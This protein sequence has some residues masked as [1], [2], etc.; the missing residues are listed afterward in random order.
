[1]SL[2]IG[3]Y[4][5]FYV[6]EPFN[7]SRLGANATRDFLYYNLIKAWSASDAS[8]NFRDSHALTYNVRDGSDWETT[9]K[10]RL[11]ARIRA[12]KN[13]LFILSSVT[14]NSRA[15]RE[16]IDYAI[17]DQS[18]PVIVIYPEF[19]T[20]ESL[21]SNG[22]ISQ[23]I[24]NLWANVPVFRDSVHKVPTLH[25]PWAKDLIKLALN[26]TDLMNGSGAL[27]IQYFYKV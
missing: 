9:L 16:E 23:R 6:A 8:F 14:V 18:L 13:V 20:K 5:A 19:T 21:L 17:N 1:M 3:N 12:S 25:V 10:P 22:G 11:R 24:R 15:L 27:P 4:T 26:D 7:P 2:R